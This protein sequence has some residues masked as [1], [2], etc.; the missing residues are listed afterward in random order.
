MTVVVPLGKDEPEAGLHVAVALGQLSF[1]FG[2]K[3]TTAEHWLVSLHCVMLAGQ[4]IV[5]FIVS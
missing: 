1:T 3:E 5:G 4:V 2:A